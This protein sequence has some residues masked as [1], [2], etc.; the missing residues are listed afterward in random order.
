MR[1]PRPIDSEHNP[2]RGRWRRRCEVYYHRRLMAGSTGVRVGS[3]Q[4]GRGS[5]AGARGRAAPVLGALLCALCA[6]CAPNWANYPEVQAQGG[7]VTVELSGIGPESGR[8]LTYRTSAGEPVGFFVYRES[9]GIP[10]AVLDACRT[11]FRWKK[12]YVL[13]GKEVVCLK[14]DMRFKLDGLAGGSGSCVPV[15]LKA[16]QRADALVIPAA[17]L[18]AGRRFF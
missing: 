2:R 18:E 4:G 14:C 6:G 8:F 15:P 3:D 7:V 12:G 11:C 5:S 16:E 13:E 9:S 17:E 1:C 10:H